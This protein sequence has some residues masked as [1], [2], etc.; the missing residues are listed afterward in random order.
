MAEPVQRQAVRGLVLDAE[1]ACC[2]FASSIRER[3]QLVGD[4]R[5]RVDPGEN[6]EE[7]LRRELLEEAGLEEFVIGPMIH[8]REHT[9]P[10]DARLI[11]QRERFY[12]C[13]STRTTPCRRSTSPRRVSPR[14]VGGRSASSTPPASGSS[15]P[16][17][18]QLVRSLAP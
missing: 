4:D 15:R 7:A 8:A 14:C 18:A 11:H 12:W 9:F 16:E 10:W 2:S 6:D 3:R 17:L 5:R 1:S 13:G